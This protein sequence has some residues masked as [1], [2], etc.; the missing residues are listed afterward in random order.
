V[1][2]KGHQ[3]MHSYYY[4]EAYAKMDEYKL[5]R[6]LMTVVMYGRVFFV[7]CST[8]SGLFLV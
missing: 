4:G 7:F 3:M 8:C 6:I 1:A 5:H 2:R